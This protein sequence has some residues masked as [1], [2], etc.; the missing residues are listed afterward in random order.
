MKTYSVSFSVVIHD[1]ATSYPEVK[2]VDLTIRETLP[3]NVDPQKYLRQRISEE[4]SRAFSH[5]PQI[6]NCDEG[7]DTQADPLAA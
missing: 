6:E 4:L 3:A 2:P 1:K 5:K 7:V